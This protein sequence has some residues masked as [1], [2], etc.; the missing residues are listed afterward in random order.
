MVK[1]HDFAGYVQLKHSE[2]CPA[3]SVDLFT[4]PDSKPYSE[5]EGIMDMQMQ[6]GGEFG[7]EG[8]DVEAAAMEGAENVNDEL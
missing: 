5:M 1:E 7:F 3:D 8:E 6:G 4:L 2:N